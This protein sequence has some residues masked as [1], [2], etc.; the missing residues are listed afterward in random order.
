LPTFISRY[1]QLSTQHAKAEFL[2]DS[3]SKAGQ[4][5]T[6]MVPVNA[7]FRIV[8]LLATAA[9]TACSGGGG[10]GSVPPPPA[11]SGWQQGVFLDADTFIAKCAAPRSGNHPISGQPW[12]DMQGTTLDENNFLRSY[13]DDT[14]LWY[15]EIVD[16]DPGLFNDPLVYF[17]ELMTSALSPSGQPK[18]KFHF[19]VPTDEWLQFSQS[20]VSIGYGVEWQFLSA[21]PPR[22]A[23]VAY[24]EPN[25]PATDPLVGLARGAELLF[26]DGVDF[27]NDNTEA[28]VDIINAALFP[29]Q[30]GKQNTFTIRDLGSPNIR[31]V[32]MT[33]ASISL[34][35]VQ[36]VSTVV[37]PTGTVG[38]ML[39]NDHIAVAEEGLVDAVKLLVAANIT[40]LVIDMRYN[41]GGFLAIASELAY[42]IAGTVP[43]AGQ[44]FEL[45]QFNDKHPVTDP[46]TGAAISPTPF[47]NTTLGPPFPLPSGQ[48][49]PTLNLSRVFVLTGSGTCSASE[50]V[51]NGLRGVDV[52]VI[53][54]GSTTCGKPYGFYATDNCGISYFTIQFRGVNQ[55]NFGD[56]SDGFSP[57]NSLPVE[58]VPLP[59]CSVLDDFTKPLGD[60]TEARFAVA[61]DYRATQ[62]CPLP[63]GFLPSGQLKPGASPS[64]VGR[65]VAEPPWRTNRIMERQ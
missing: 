33:S 13:S 56:Y 14:Y 40:D 16:Q 44:T 47:F 28:G 65:V 17:D 64:T 52:E 19:V 45:L 32:M 21:A 62:M 26:V 27:V 25:S 30:T 61:L 46:V 8:I 43:T 5:R 49:L 1:Y 24:T 51:I 3:E 58:G 38:Y 57:A 6:P 9:M 12:P 63:T 31:V 4:I 18:D 36:N 22:Q 29:T 41:G 35:P 54:I 23:L 11:G 10:S 7:I 2:L 42:M 39:F 48:P 50:A 60:P 20:G 15:D 37:T 55:K 59:G 34:T 53:Q